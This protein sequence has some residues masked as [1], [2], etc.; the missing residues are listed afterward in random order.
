MLDFETCI[1]LVIVLYALFMTWS[2]TNLHFQS[3]SQ[4]MSIFSSQLQTATTKGRLPNP[5]IDHL[6]PRANHSIETLSLNQMD[7]DMASTQH[8]YHNVS[9]PESDGNKNDVRDQNNNSISD[10]YKTRESLT[11]RPQYVSL[12]EKVNL[13]KT[14]RTTG[15]TVSPEAHREGLIYAMASSLRPDSAMR[16][17]RGNGTLNDSI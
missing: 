8:N 6:S 3:P 11:Q 13:F 17:R 12:A 14:A 10:T 7:M 9:V 5:S 4:S 15:L 2:M 16:F 1:I